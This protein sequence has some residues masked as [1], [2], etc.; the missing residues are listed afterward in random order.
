MPWL[1]IQHSLVLD[2]L[3]IKF[4]SFSLAFFKPPKQKVNRALTCLLE[5]T[6]S[7]FR[8]LFFSPLCPNGVSKQLSNSIFLATVSLVILKWLKPSIRTDITFQFASGG[9]A[10]G[11][12]V[13]P[14]RRA[15]TTC[16]GS[17]A[18]SPTAL[19]PP[20]CVRAPHMTRLLDG[21]PLPPFIKLRGNFIW[22]SFC[23]SPV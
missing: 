21:A 1:V 3:V 2:Y 10:S 12:R 13:A 7:G 22:S 5:P 18:S 19:A 16:P 15:V 9:N 4:W 17:S 20:F 8:P 11:W 14:Q 23:S 6:P